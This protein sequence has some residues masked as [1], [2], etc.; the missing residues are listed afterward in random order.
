MGVSE[1][2]LTAVKPVSYTHL[3]VYKRQLCVL[4][5][6]ARCVYPAANMKTEPSALGCQ[7]WFNWS[8]RPQRFSSV[9]DEMGLMNTVSSGKSATTKL[10]GSSSLRVTTAPSSS[11]W[12]KNARVLSLIHISTPAS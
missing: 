3:D 6:G 4:Q 12:R 5:P 10:F 2:T 1:V 7:Y 11:A 9:F 8:I